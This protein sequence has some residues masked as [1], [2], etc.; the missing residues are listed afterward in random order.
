MMNMSTP[1]VNSFE[2][3]NQRFIQIKF[4]VDEGDERLSQES[5]EDLIKQ[6]KTSKIPLFINGSSGKDKAFLWKQI[7]GYYTDAT[8]SPDM[9]SITATAKLNKHHEDINQ[10]WDYLQNKMPLFMNV[11]FLPTSYQVVQE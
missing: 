10:F 8:L 6:F 7:S 4:S 11:N 9:R 3:D 2:K 5:R 1:I